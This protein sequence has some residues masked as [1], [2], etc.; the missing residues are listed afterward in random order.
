MRTHFSSLGAPDLVIEQ[1][2]DGLLNTPLK[3]A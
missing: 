3:R 1:E 2:E